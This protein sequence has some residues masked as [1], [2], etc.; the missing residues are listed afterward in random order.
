MYKEP[1]MPSKV[2]GPVKRCYKFFMC[3]SS[4]RIM[5]L[6]Y[7]AIRFYPSHS[8]LFSTNYEVHIQLSD[9]NEVISYRKSNVFFIKLVTNFGERIDL[10]FDNK[11]LCKEWIC[12]LNKALDYSDYLSEKMNY[13][14][15]DSYDKLI[16]TL[17]EK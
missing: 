6:N 8:T 13:Y 2:I 7:E 9:I 15:A 1:E 4:S 5:V 16:Q 3:M 10:R 12:Y 14:R 11:D 17:T